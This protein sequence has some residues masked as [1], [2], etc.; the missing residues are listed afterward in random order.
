MPRCDK[1]LERARNNPKEVRFSDA[2][3]LAECYGFSQD[4]QRGSH[5]WF[6]HPL[7][8]DGLNL[9]DRKGMAKE[10]QVKQ[11]LDAINELIERGYSQ[12]ESDDE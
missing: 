12:E 11:L 7:L 5:Q 3:K 1:L 4:R 6:E 9:Q 2:V 10:Y 8:R